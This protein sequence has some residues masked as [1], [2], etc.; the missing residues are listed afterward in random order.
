VDDPSEQNRRRFLQRMDEA[1][2]A[3]HEGK[4]ATLAYALG[5][6]K[7]DVER[8][9]GISGGPYVSSRDAAPSIERPDRE[10]DRR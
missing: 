8:L 2:Q 9:G 4:A 5:V 3:L 6:S 1:Q 10:R 7:Q